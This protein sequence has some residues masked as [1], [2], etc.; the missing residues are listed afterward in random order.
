MAERSRVSSDGAG[1]G[2]EAGQEKAWQ[3]LAEAGP[4]AVAE[5]DGLLTPGEVAAVVRFIARQHPAAV[6]T[7]LWAVCSSKDLVAA[8]SATQ[9]SVHDYAEIAASDALVSA[10][11]TASA[12][13]RQALSAG[14]R[15]APPGV[16]QRFRAASQPVK[17]PAE[18]P[19]EDQ[20]I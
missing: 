13:G 9:P 16:R 11:L 17:R 18:G 7:L 3:A 4:H 1:S 19:C 15:S 10:V 2:Q 12:A 5:V 8:C 14:L 6:E 20:P